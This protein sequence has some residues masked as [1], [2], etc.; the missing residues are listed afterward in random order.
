M[1]IEANYR[2]ILHPDMK[3]HHQLLHTATSRNIEDSDIRYATIVV[4]SISSIAA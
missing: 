3:V 1:R 2:P 4:V